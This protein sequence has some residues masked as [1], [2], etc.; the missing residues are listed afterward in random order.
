MM[1]VTR[2][3][4]MDLLPLYL[5]GEASAETNALVEEFLGQDPELRRQAELARRDLPAAQPMGPL[6]LPPDLELRSLRRTQALLR[7]QRLAFTFAVTFS[8]LSLTSV[9]SFEAGRPHYRLLIL[10]YPQIF[11]PCAGLAISGWL[12]YYFF[13]LR[14]LR[15][16]KR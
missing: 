13:V 4:V 11:G 15:F 8:C 10:E 1:T 12:H 2:N 14:K 6:A 16:R 3:V 5:A 7:W 9:I